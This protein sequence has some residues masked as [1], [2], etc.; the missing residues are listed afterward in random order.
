MNMEKMPNFAEGKENENINENNV[1]EI[2]ENEVE[3][4]AEGEMTKEQFESVKEDIDELEKM[5]PE[6]NNYSQEE[7][8]EKYE[9]SSSFRDALD[10]AKYIVAALGFGGSYAIGMAMSGPDIKQAL[11]TVAGIVGTAVITSMMSKTS[12]AQ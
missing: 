5:A 8:Q 12:K 4:S 11:V 3:N 1:E 6:F 2:K 7:I 9:S 10:N